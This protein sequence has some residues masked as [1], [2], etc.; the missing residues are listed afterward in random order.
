MAI[1]YN[2]PDDERRV[3]DA[4]QASVFNWCNDTFGDGEESGPRV[5]LLRFIEEACELAQ[6]GELTVADVHKVV[7]YVFARPVGE[8]DQEMGGVMVTLYA[9]GA[10]VGRS[11][12]Q[13]ERN[14]I[15]RVNSK[16]PERFQQRAREKGEAGIR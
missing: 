3:R 9:Y 16:P 2:F 13:Y 5:R 11:V 6:A 14:E 12:A 15:V 10:S 4:R 7:D 1:E 8:I